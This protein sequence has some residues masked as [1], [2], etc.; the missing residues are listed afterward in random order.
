MALIKTTDLG[1]LLKLG[2]NKICG[3]SANVVDEWKPLFETSQSNQAEEEDLE[4]SGLGMGE[5]TPEGASIALGSMSTRYITR[6]RHQKVSISFQI[7]QEALADNLYKNQFIQQAKSFANSM[8]TT[9]N[10]LAANIFN[11]AF[12]PAHYWGDGQALCSSTHQIDGGTYS[13]LLT[14]AGGASVDLCETAVEEA[15]IMINYFKQ[16]NG[17]F[18]YSKAKFLLIPPALEHQARRLTR[19]A[20]RTDTANNDISSIVDGKYIPGGYIVNRYLM[21]PTA[22]FLT[23]D[24]DTGF[25]HFVRE[26]MKT[27]AYTDPMTK[28]ILLSAWERYS[29]GC[30]NPRAVI[31]SRGI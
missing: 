25:R 18:T 16:Q 30:S 29:L 4:I 23:T 13:N 9:K 27:D 17:M 8:R 22:W 14:G 11:N 20:F 31:G 26:G 10:V 19:S 21:S 28:N 1:P 5:L 6:Y 3:D 12:D 24:A 2:L 15:L 7:T